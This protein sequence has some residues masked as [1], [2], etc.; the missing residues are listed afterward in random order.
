MLRL[1][2]WFHTSAEV[3]SEESAVT[4]SCLV[5][6]ELPCI[7][8][9]RFRGR[10]LRR[11]LPCLARDRS[12]N[13]TRML[14][15]ARPRATRVTGGAWLCALCAMSCQQGAGCLHGKFAVRPTSYHS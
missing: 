10:M 6:C 13:F 14:Y 4:T 5:D 12:R 11:A 3:S 2:S 7:A 9:A 15:E 8:K 1:L